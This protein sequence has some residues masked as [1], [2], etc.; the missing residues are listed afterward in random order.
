MQG[1][2]VQI[3][4]G[5]CLFDAFSNALERAK[6][7]GPLP[8]SRAELRR[9]ALEAI[10]QDG[11][12]RFIGPLVE[13]IAAYIDSGNPAYRDDNHF[14]CHQHI[15]DFTGR[16]RDE[17]QRRR[18]ENLGEMLDY[19]LTGV[20]RA[21][22][23]T[24]T[25]SGFE[26]YLGALWL[27]VEGASRGSD[28]VWSTDPSVLQRMM[29]PHEARW[30]S[31]IELDALGKLY[32]ICIEVENQGALFK[33][34]ANCG[35]VS[36]ISGDDQCELEARNILSQEN[37]HFVI[38][39][40]NRGEL[41]ERLG[42]IQNLEGV[43]KWLSSRATYVK[44]VALHAPSDSQDLAIRKS[45]KERGVLSVKVEGG[46]TVDCFGE[47]DRHT[48]QRRIG[49][50]SLDLRDKV[51]S[52]YN[53]PM[54]KVRLIHYPGHWGFGAVIQP[55]P[56]SAPGAAPSAAPTSASSADA[57]PPAHAAS[58]AASSPPPPPPS[59]RPV[60]ILPPPPVV[61]P[62]SPPLAPVPLTLTS[63]V[64]QARQT[65]T[66]VNRRLELYKQGLLKRQNVLVA[67][68]N[69]KEALGKDISEEAIE[70]GLI[71]K[72]VGFIERAQNALNGPDPISNRIQAFTQ[73]ANRAI[74]DNSMNTH[75]DRG[76]TWFFRNVLRVIVKAIPKMTFSI[77]SETKGVRE[78]REDTKILDKVGR[79][80][81]LG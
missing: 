41:V 78:L 75:R 20:V 27:P 44:N 81:S 71:E 54:A 33:I 60:P 58:D 34:G 16:V 2:P 30:G 23:L 40:E 26:G 29:D 55:Y 52:A 67:Q 79:A 63:S 25:S 36:G 24:G 21:F 19:W 56:N 50:V 15:R 65:L 66:E 6:Y 38:K 14:L 62:T 77:F 74:A 72:K 43:Q 47:V 35:E 1:R 4:S 9:L 18:S 3:D 57:A 69:K 32:G 68:K 48:I 13:A 49:A 39:I 42:V 45:L 73:V 51:L 46:S 10:G 17:Y 59:P 70:I 7:R 28:D 61:T 53:P 22:W 31:E 12:D 8:K 64:R 5:N 80:F 37:G 11:G 76:F